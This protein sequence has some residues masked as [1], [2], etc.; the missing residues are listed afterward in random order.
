AIPSAVQAWQINWGDGFGFESDIQ[1][2]YGNPGSIIHVYED[3]GRNRTITAIAEDQGGAL[4]E[5][6]AVPVTVVNVA[7]TVDIDGARPTMPD[8][9]PIN[10]AAVA[11]DRGTADQ[12]TYKWTIQKDG[13]PFDVGINDTY[14]FT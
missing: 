6:N 5:S 1:T 13:Q 9:Q 8:D 14:Q 12:L 11:S 4:Y 10:L 2:V 7:P 3:G